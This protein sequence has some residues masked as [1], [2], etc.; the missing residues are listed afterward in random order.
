[1]DDTVAST[2]TAPRSNDNTNG[3]DM[4]I[5][6]TIRIFVPDGDPESVRIID[7]MNWTGLGLA[8]PRDKW[9]GVKH[10][11]EFANAGV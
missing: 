1:M 2:K 9:M 7:R 5:P 10:R 4:S 8:F 11:P 6:Y 3:Q